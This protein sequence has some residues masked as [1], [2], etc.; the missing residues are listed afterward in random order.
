[1]RNKEPLKEILIATRPHWDHPQTR[2]AVR[3]NFLKV[4][5][6]RTGVLGA[7]VFASQTEE[8]IVNHTCKSRSCPSCGYRATLL[9]LREQWNALPDIRY[10]GIVF[11]MPSILWPIFKKNRH[12]LHDLP[13]LGAAV[14]EQ[15]GKACGVRQL[16]MVVQHTFGAYL[17]F[18]CHLHILVS[19]GGLL[20][21]EG[22]W[23][24][25]VRL[26]K[27]AL[28]RAWRYAVIAYLR[29]AVKRHVLHSDPEDNN[30]SR[31]LTSEYKYPR[32][33][34][35]LRESMPKTHFLVYAARYAR[36]LPIA[37]RRISRVAGGMVE[38]WTK[39]K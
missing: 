36:R 15:C 39:D 33:V 13:A 30:L 34:I 17:N 2:P 3:E 12:L 16:I 35:Y 18:N 27:K 38:F 32:W 8:K 37:Q 5:E 21:S 29:E 25:S 22:R 7:E 1:M 24:P 26:D 14:I 19:A 6:C 23:I 20:E 9:W 11:T 4:I 10:T 31:I 28:M